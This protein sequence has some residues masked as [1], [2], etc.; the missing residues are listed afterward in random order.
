MA[1]TKTL[2]W[3]GIKEFYVALRPT[4]P[5]QDPNWVRV[6]SIEQATVRATFSKVEVYGDNTLQYTFVHSPQVSVEV[7]LTKFSGPVAEILTGNTGFSS[8]GKE[9]MYIMTSKDLNP[10]QVMLRLVLPAKDDATGAAK[11]AEII[12]FKA[13]V[14]PIWDNFGAERGKATELSWRF[15]SLI[16]TIDERGNTLPEGSFGK[17]LFPTA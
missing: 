17:Y 1:L 10:T 4:A 14:E 9:G 12:V 5:N 3:F 13:E 8:S 11:D 6:P 15:N 2:Y 7:K 16:S